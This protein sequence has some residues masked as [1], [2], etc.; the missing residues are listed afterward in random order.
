MYYVRDVKAETKCAKAT[1]ACG[2][3][4]ESERAKHCELL[5]RQKE[6]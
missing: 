4:T 2:T 6:Y 5:E 1:D 3:Y